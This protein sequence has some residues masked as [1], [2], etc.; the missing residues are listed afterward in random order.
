VT[1]RAT[2]QDFLVEVGTEEL[3]PKTLFDL[4][5][6]FG[7]G[8]RAGLLRAGLA[9]GEVRTFATPRRLAV[10]VKRVEAQQAARELRRRGPPVSIAFDAA[11]QPTRAALA[12]AEGCGVDVSALQRVVEGK[13]EFLLHVGVQ[14]GEPATA[15]LPGIVQASLDQL[16]IAKRMRW[17]AGDAQ[18]VRPVHWLLML[19]GRE[20]VQAKI[21][22]TAAGATTR[23][24]RFH[25]P[26]PLRIASPGSYAKTL[27]SRGKVIADG[28]ERRELIEAHVRLHA[29]QFEGGRAVYS[30]AL[31]DE[32]AALVEWPVVLTGGFEARFLELPREVLISTLQEHQ[33]YFP[34]EDERTGA[35]LP[36]FI[37]VAN[38][39]S[40]ELDKVRA[41]NERV[42]R[43][44]LADA[45]F[46]WQQDR[47]T[48]L[49]ARTAALSQVTFQAKL[50]TLADKS[51][52]VRALA[53]EIAGALGYEVAL[54]QRAAELAKCD[55]LSAMVGEFP[56]LQGT[57]GSYYAAADGEPDEVARAL[58]EQYLPRFSGDA[59]PETG[60]GTAIAIADRIDTIVGIF[61]IGQKPSGTKDPFALRRAALGVLRISIEKG[62]DLDLVTLIERAASLVRERSAG[63]ADLPADLA[64]QVYGYIME[65]LRA[66]YLEGATS[67]PVTTERFDAVLATRPRSPLD[68]DARLRAL[69]GFLELPEAASLTAANKRI[70]NILRKSA[71]AGTAAHES[72]E[73]SALSE[74]P[75]IALH[76]ALRSVRDSVGGALERREYA[77][78]LGRLAQLRPTVDAFFDGVMVMDED[79]KRRGNRLAMLSE[80]QRLFGGIADLSR[81]PG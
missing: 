36:S 12:F 1:A 38:I 63:V 15:L 81:L 9:H 55:L 10:L 13:G 67:L 74:P 78:A 14:P 2:R 51:W 32:V 25:A 16:P 31:L 33:R 76:D 18:F 66:Y 39:E 62:L 57:M 7:E 23:G 72:I 54:A 44:R 60:A 26:K 22:D 75:E 45:S 61:A 73:V 30:D 42:V 24:H 8:I 35:L 79:A 41:G 53:T 49:A 70:A 56:D 48:P 69:S 4:E 58:R 47:R 46:F 43:P 17:G 11:G 80:L 27:A 71:D 19:F 21:L 5:R 29:A 59:L 52:R 68:F 37:A 77:G 40:R 3:P 50:G 20:V 6:A 28:R 64:T 34:V 65:R